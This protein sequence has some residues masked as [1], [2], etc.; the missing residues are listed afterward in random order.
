MNDF[1]KLLPPQALL[2]Y[3][4]LLK[5]KELTA[6]RVTPTDISNLI[7]NVEYH[8]FPGSCLT[9]CCITLQN[10]FTVIG[11]SA[12]ASPDNFDKELGEK[13]PKMS[14]VSLRIL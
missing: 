4:T 10:G 14:H 13:I 7:K 5:E 8:L 6:P 12:C 11:T 2:V 1:R 9:V 3:K